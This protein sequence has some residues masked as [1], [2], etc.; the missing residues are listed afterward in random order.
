MEK[1]EEG[2]HYQCVFYGGAILSH[3][4][5]EVSPGDD[6]FIQ[7]LRINRNAIVLMDSDKSKEDDLLKGRVDRVLQEIE[8]TSSTSAWVTCGREVENYLPKD[9]LEEY[10]ETSVS[11]GKFQ[12][13]AHLFKKQ[14]EVESFDKVKFAS[15]ITKLAG[16]TRPRLEKHLDLKEKI[17]SVIEHIRK[18]NS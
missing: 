13:F 8:K 9:L 10:F 18:C 14:K 2:L 7:M 12:N 4:T 5:V 3:Y 6:K 17:G 11:F 1:L 16:Y 15:E